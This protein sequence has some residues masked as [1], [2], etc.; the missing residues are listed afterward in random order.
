MKN[1]EWIELGLIPESKSQVKSK[2]LI[3][4]RRSS[5]VDSLLQFGELGTRDEVHKRLDISHR[6]GE[7]KVRLGTG[8]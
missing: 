3:E 8:V 5:I 7:T 1:S 6:Y 2:N 4:N